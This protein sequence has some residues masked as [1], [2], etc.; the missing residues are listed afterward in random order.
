MRWSTGALAGA[1]SLAGV[2]LWRMRPQPSEPED[3]AWEPRAL[4]RFA[5][6][7]PRP[8]TS[9]VGMSVAAVWASPMTV[10]GLL[11]AATALAPVHLTSEGFLVTGARGPLGAVLRRRGFRATTLGHV[12]ITLDEPSPA[13]LA[14]EQLHSR[15]VERLGPAFGPVYVLL[16]VLYGYRRHPME[17][18]ARRAGR[19]V[20]GD[21]TGVG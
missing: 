11:L 21:A 19:R 20:A 4:A 3:P 2:L 10:A 7:E 8:V 5:R 18:A 14:H 9:P 13:L 12:V 15:Q 1:C 16:L 17:R 6:W